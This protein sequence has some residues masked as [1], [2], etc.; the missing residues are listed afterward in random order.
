MHT[1]IDS[2]LQAPQLDSREALCWALPTTLNSWDSGGFISDSVFASPSL[3]PSGS[4][5]F[6]SDHD[7]RSPSR[8]NLCKYACSSN[9][10]VV[11]KEGNTT[12]ILLASIRIPTSLCIVTWVGQR[13]CCLLLAIMARLFTVKDKHHRYPSPAPC[14]KAGTMPKSPWY[15]SSPF[16]SSCF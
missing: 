9:S 7:I 10:H 13:Y 6:L 3:A 4:F 16:T 15:L 8:I 12:F 2:S 1:S 14:Q 5:H 11:I